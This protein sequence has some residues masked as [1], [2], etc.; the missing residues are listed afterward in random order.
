MGFKHIENLT[1]SCTWWQGACYIFHS[2]AL[3]EQSLLTGDRQY[4]A[5]AKD[6]GGDNYDGGDNDVGDND[7]G[8]DNDNGDN[9]DGGDKD[10]GDNDV[11]GNNDDGAIMSVVTTMTVRK[12]TVTTMSRATTMR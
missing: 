7:V 1:D 8:G 9:D 2:L 12:M 4:H 10:D 3:M 11:D 6:V 5:T